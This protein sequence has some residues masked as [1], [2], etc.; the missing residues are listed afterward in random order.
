MILE[1]LG[2][3]CLALV[4]R[5]EVYFETGTSNSATGLT[6]ALRYSADF[7]HAPCSGIPATSP[8]NERPAMTYKLLESKNPDSYHLEVTHVI[9]L[10]LV[11]HKL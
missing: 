10:S 3:S 7:R 4:D 5:E 8:T 1:D 6:K 11:I 9:F 2:L